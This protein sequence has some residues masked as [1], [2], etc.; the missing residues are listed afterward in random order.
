M[1]RKHSFW[2]FV[3]TSSR[4]NNKKNSRRTRRSKAFRSTMLGVES[5]EDRA[6]LAAGDLAATFGTGGLVVDTLGLTTKNKE[7]YASAV[8]ADGKVV[9]AGLINNTGTSNRDFLV[10]RY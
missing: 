10:A 4:K 7:I 1:L 9:V 2:N 3:H 5:L 6:L 8:Q